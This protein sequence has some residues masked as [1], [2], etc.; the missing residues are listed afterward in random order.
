MKTIGTVVLL[1]VAGAL[2]A[3]TADARILGEVEKL[4]MK[5]YWSLLD[6]GQRAEAKAIA[7]R[8]LADTAPDRLAVEARVAKYR[9]DV[10]ALLSPEQRRE[11]VRILAAVKRMAPGSRRALLDRLLDRTDRAA[12]AGKVERI[13]SAAAPEQVALGVE[14]LDDVAEVM[15]AVF[16]EKLSLTAEQTSGIRTLY[17]DLKADL[18]PVA[19]RLAEAKAAAAREGLALLRPEQKARLDEFRAGLLGKVIAFLRG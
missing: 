7:E 3:S 18:L 10:A 6:E 15:L 19:G 8:Y 12:L 16:T 13:A 5:A 1:A 17:A 11:A 2:L 9:A 14:V 4:G